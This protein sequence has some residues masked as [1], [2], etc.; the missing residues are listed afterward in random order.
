MGNPLAKNLI[1]PI[2]E[3]IVYSV[4]IDGNVY[5]HKRSGD[6]L[7]KQYQ[8][9]ARGS[10]VYKGVRAGKRSYLVHRLMMAAKLG[11]MLR[12]DEQ[13][14]HINGDTQDNRMA[15]LEVVSHQQN[16][17]HAVENKLYCSGEAWHKA[18]SK[19]QKTSSND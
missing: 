4:D 5:S 1:L 6:R 16:V 10:N 14:N 13:V 19:D 9:K 18:R 7:L 2:Q 15:N 3:D 17:Q 11:R 8:H 12:P